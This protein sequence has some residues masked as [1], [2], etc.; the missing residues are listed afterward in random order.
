M[1][2][3]SRDSAPYRGIQNSFVL[4]TDAP[5]WIAVTLLSCALVFAGVQ[6]VGLLR[7]A[8]RNT[9]KPTSTGATRHPL[10]RDTQ[11]HAHAR[12]GLLNG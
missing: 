2:C 11:S 9:G 5:L 12:S 4:L 1:V 3:R 7:G 8:E 6:I 10:S